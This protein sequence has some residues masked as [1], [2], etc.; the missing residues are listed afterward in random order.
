MGDIYRSVVSALAVCGLTLLVGCP[1]NLS[2]PDAFLDGGTELKDAETIFAD[3]CGKSDCHDDSA[4]ASDL[5]LLSPG[6]EA[7]LINVNA[8]GSGC[9]NKILVVAGDPDSSYLMDKVLDAPGICFS[10]MPVPGTGELSAEE[11]EVIR[12]WII[13]LGGSAGGLTDGG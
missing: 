9:T 10:P 11:I 7:R 4:P 8:I 2:N 5:N 1:G 3:S 12:Q 13:D 6:V